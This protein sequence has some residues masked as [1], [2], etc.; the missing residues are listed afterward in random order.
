[1]F[2]LSVKCIDDVVLSLFNKLVVDYCPE[3]FAELRACSHTLDNAD[4]FEPSLLGNV[5]LMSDLREEDHNLLEA[6]VLVAK[7][8][9]RA[10]GEDLSKELILNHCL[11]SIMLDGKEANPVHYERRCINDSVLMLDDLA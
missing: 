9:L 11:V 6:L 3:L 7:D 8:K 4:E 1:V 10:L 2:S 5:L